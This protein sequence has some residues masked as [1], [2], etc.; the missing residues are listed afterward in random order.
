M[1]EYIDITL[2]VIPGLPVWPESLPITFDKIFDMQKGD[3][4]TDT[5]LHLSAHSGTHVDAPAH[6]VNDGKNLSDF[7]LSR[8]IGPVLVVDL[9]N[10]DVITAKDLAG[11][12][13]PK[14]TTRLLIRT[15]NSDLWA[16]PKHEFNRD[17]VALD[18][19]AAQWLVDFGMELIGIDYLSIQPF[20]HGPETHQ[21]ILGADIIAIEGVNLAGVEAGDY[22]L[23]C[24]PLRL[25]NTEA[26]PVRAL[27]RKL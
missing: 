14:A 18:Q 20:Y 8:F 4:H 10:I 11:L 7:P 6:F 5:N 15:K 12:A 19:G 2:P 22:E 17:F 16:N 13:I 23:Y 3:P 24:L 21:I 1:N 9:P 27:L 26:A 25:M